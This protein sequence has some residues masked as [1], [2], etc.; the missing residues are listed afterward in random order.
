MKGEREIR[1]SAWVM[2]LVGVPP[3]EKG[4]LGG[5]KM[6]GRKVYLFFFYD[7]KT[8]KQK[9]HQEAWWDLFLD[10]V[11]NPELWQ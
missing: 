10:Q 9:L 1:V 11:L 6:G 2:G 3:H 4:T 7:F 5:R 8:N